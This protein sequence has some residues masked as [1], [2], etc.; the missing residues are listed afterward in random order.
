MLNNFAL[1]GILWLTLC[2][3]VTS[4]PVA[5]PIVFVIN[6]FKNFV[7]AVTNNNLIFVN[8]SYLIA[9]SVD[10][11]LFLSPTGT[12]LNRVLLPFEYIDYTV[13][14]HDTSDLSYIAA[15]GFG[16][17]T[18]GPS[19]VF[20]TMKTNINCTQAKTM[21][22]Y[23]DHIWVSCEG[24]GLVAFDQSLSKNTT[25]VPEEN[26]SYCLY[27]TIDSTSNMLFA[28]CVHQ[29]LVVVVNSSF[30][31]TLD[32][33]Q[34]SMDIDGG[35]IMSNVFD[36]SLI[37]LCMNVTTTEAIYYSLNTSS[38]VLKEMNGVKCH[39]ATALYLGPQGTLT[40]SCM[41]EGIIQM[42][43]FN[44]NVS[45]PFILPSI[46]LANVDQCGNALKI[47]GND[48]TG[49]LFVSCT[50]SNLGTLITIAPSRSLCQDKTYLDSYLDPTCTL[51]KT[52]FYCRDGYI[53]PCVNGSLCSLP[54]LDAPN[55]LCP[56]GFICIDGAQEPCPLGYSC[57]NSGMAEGIICPFGSYCD[58][59]TVNPVPCPA[60]YV[61]S[62]PSSI[63]LCPVFFYCPP[64]STA[65][66]PCSS[67][68]T[69]GASTIPVISPGST[70]VDAGNQ[71]FVQ[72][73]IIGGCISGGIG[74]LFFLIKFV[75]DFTARRHLEHLL[76]QS[77]GN[78]SQFKEYMKSVVKPTTLKVLDHIKTTGFLGWRSDRNT[79]AYVK[80]IE[81]VISTIHELGVNTDLLRLKD[82]Q[83]LMLFNILVQAF[84]TSLGRR[85][86]CCSCSRLKSWIRPDATPQQFQEYE[87]VIA[88]SIYQTCLSSHPELLSTL[89]SDKVDKV[90]NSHNTPSQLQLSPLYRTT[91]SNHSYHEFNKSDFLH[92]NSFTLPV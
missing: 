11:I 87:K 62:T 73:A 34:K 35:C 54:G 3:Y 65:P 72:K 88:Q 36:S 49:T 37:V 30:I 39:S 64:N 85:D 43:I 63:T 81:T 89:S 58:L 67:C 27:M 71:D 53:R 17:Y 4:Q 68:T 84:E 16:L 91:M 33:Q 12:L 25:V 24:V 29:G 86:V 9:G 56:P 8:N 80:S 1:F 45:P 90:D 28:L 44:I 40:V 61:C 21:V 18:F 55:M 14:I 5:I 42:S 10:Q 46:L 69:S 31:V 57:N 22:L 59:G 6:G 76:D 83:K 60:G 75:L 70:T 20:P 74:L 66:I 82:H 7:S 78:D 19:S 23:E 2:V 50:T 48:I 52:N 92:N 15:D 47:A 32:I 38:L 79:K 41:T 51:C 26:N 13:I 77:V